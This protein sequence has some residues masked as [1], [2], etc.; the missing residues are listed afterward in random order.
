MRI[1]HLIPQLRFGAGRAVVDLAVRQAAAD[2]CDDV[3]ILVAADADAPFVSDARLI[4]ESLRRGVR[5]HVAGDFFHRTV[6][7]LR[8][9][10]RSIADRAGTRGPWIAHAHTAMAAAAAHLAGAHAVIGTCHGVAQG[11]P[12]EIEVQDALAWRLCD[13]V[14]SPSR[15]WADRLTSDFAV[16][17]PAVVPYGLDLAAYPPGPR[18]AG[19]SPFRLVTVAELT[20]RKGVDVL[21]AALPGIWERLGPAE[22]HIM[23]DG[24]S[25]QALRDE[26][27]RIDSG[28][29][30]VVFH[31]HVARPYER[32]AAF[33]LFVLPSRSDNQPIA[34]IE[35]MLAACPIVATMVGGLGEMVDDAGCGWVVPPDDPG[36]LARAITTAIDAGVDARDRLGA[37]GEG[38]ARRAYDIDAAVT[39]C[40]AVYERARRVRPPRA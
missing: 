23:G 32:L 29:G 40:R 39:A 5:V 35:A 30:R 2:W 12:A 31:G 19:A 34:A 14:I 4:D 37:R 1:V 21:L 20:P 11:R 16:P 28:R 24:E 38:F 10:A 22:C 7:G 26:A 36:A 6:R 27:R 3:Q 8:E 9:A 18:T 17:A 25:A 33:D 13:A 15:H